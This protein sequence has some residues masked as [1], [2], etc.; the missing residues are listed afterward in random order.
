MDILTHRVRFTFA[1]RID[2]LA[3]DV[4]EDLVEASYNREKR[5]ILRKYGDTIRISLIREIGNTGTPYLFPLQKL[6]GIQ[7]EFTI[8]YCVPGIRS[9]RIETQLDLQ[10]V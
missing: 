3:L 10:S 7:K 8:M 2:T 9:V 5:E 6:F 1:N 4:V